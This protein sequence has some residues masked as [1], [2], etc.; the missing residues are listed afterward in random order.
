MTTCTEITGKPDVLLT[1]SETAA[2][3]GL[4]INTLEIW[5]VQGKGPHFLKVGDGLGA[6]VRYRRSDVVA[7]LEARQY[8]STSHFT[9]KKAAKPRSVEVLRHAVSANAPWLKTNT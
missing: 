8:G 1:T 4:K 5:R 7:W 9:A 3:L 6:P 2:M